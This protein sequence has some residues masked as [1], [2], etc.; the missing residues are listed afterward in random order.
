M[1][2][3]TN[4]PKKNKNRQKWL[5][6]KLKGEWMDKDRI[7]EIVLFESLIHYVEKEDDLV[8]DEKNWA[9]L[10]DAGHTRQD[11]IDEIRKRYQE[12]NQA[13]HYLKNERPALQH[14]VDNWEGTNIKEFEALEGSLLSK[15]TEIM[16]TIV[17]YRGYL[18]S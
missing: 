17:K 10:R 8:F 2:I 6:D 1:R 3:L 13:Y 7:I 16:N 15:D 18:W 14:Q 4:M 11:T 9:R 12:L 5:T